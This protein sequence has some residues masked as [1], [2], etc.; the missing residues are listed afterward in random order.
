[1]LKKIK[2]SRQNYFEVNKIFIEKI[3][4]LEFQLKIPENEGIFKFTEKIIE[5]IKKDFKQEKNIEDRITVGRTDKNIPIITFQFKEDME[6]EN[7][8]NE[9]EIVKELDNTSIFS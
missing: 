9:Y 8:S 3:K 7:V 4:T 2:L 1:M 5:E 6:I